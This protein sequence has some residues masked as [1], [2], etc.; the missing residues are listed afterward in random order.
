M[1]KFLC[2]KLFADCLFRLVYNSTH[3]GLQTYVRLRRYTAAASYTYNMAAVTIVG[4][5]TSLSPNVMKIFHT[6]KFG[7]K[8]AR[9]LNRKKAT[10]R[11]IKLK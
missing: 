1:R 7:S 10:K 2:Y 11:K 3:N 9:T 4:K 5:M 8:Y 6:P